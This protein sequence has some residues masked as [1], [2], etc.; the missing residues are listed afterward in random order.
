VLD[1]DTVVYSDPGFTNVG[2]AVTIANAGYYKITAEV[3]IDMVE[4]TSRTASLC[5][6][7]KNSTEIP[8]TKMYGYH[9]TADRGADTMTAT[10]IANLAANDVV[11]VECEIYDWGL[12]ID[13]RAQSCRLLIESI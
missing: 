3:T 13:T 12:P 9:R 4:G 7:R 11:D 6:I 2:G 8:G 10:I 5:Y 1:F